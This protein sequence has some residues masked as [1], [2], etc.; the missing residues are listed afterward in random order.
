MKVYIAVDSEGQACLTREEG[1]APCAY[2]FNHRA[3]ITG[4]FRLN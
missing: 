2:L 3:Q 1:S 4:L